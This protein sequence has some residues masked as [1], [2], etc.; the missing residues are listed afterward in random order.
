MHIKK[1]VANTMQEALRQIKKE[2]G[3]EALILSV[4][5]IKTKSGPLALM[6]PARVEVTAALDEAVPERRYPSSPLSSN[7]PANP[8]P[9]GERPYSRMHFPDFQRVSREQSRW[10]RI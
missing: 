10:P 9:Q 8:G 7:R 4:N 1:Y 5:T 3:P 6:S 2:L